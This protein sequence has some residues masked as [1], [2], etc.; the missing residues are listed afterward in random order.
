MSQNGNGVNLWIRS[1]C[2]WAL[3]QLAK[4]GASLWLAAHFRVLG[5]RLFGDALHFDKDHNKSKVFHF[6]S[7]Q[8]TQ[9][10]LNPICSD[11]LG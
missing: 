8:K 3:Q 10:H 4:H 9:L 1:P 7:A 11:I 2:V 5:I 6:T